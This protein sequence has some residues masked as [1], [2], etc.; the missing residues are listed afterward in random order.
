[1]TISI[2]NT[3]L[4]TDLSGNEIKNIS[5]PL[6]LKPYEYITDGI[7]S[8]IFYILEEKS[9]A[10]GVSSSSQLVI[11]STLLTALL[12]CLVLY[13]YSL[14]IYLIVIFYSNTPLEGLW[15]LINVLQLISY[16]MLLHLKYPKN[17]LIF[18]EALSLVH[19]F[20]TYVPNIFKFL[21]FEENNRDQPY[22]ETFEQRGFDTRTMLIL[23]GSEISLF[24]FIFM[25]IAI[26]ILVKR[27]FK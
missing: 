14:F 26:L 25:A 7:I 2:N 12:L 22:N 9:I 11:I 16:T 24:V 17:L 23:V 10:D 4:I 18:L 20:N 15:G 19:G 6:K 27:M 13:E 21:L 1:M 5:I 3:K 8:Y